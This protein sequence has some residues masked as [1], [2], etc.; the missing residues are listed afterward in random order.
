MIV[1]SLPSVVSKEAWVEAVPTYLKRQGRRQR[2]SIILAAKRDNLKS[3]ASPRDRAALFRG[4][5]GI[6]GGRER[7]HLQKTASHRKVP[8]TEFGE[9]AQSACGIEKCLARNLEKQHNLHGISEPTEKPTA[10]FP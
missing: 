10:F 9:T 6:N 5:R 4:D 8:G 2:P 7:A 3:K 1:P